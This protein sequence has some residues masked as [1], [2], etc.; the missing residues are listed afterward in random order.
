MSNNKHINEDGKFNNIVKGL[1]KEPVL[2]DPEQLTDSILKE[3]E[4]EKHITS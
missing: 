2:K 1:K 4:N 3:I